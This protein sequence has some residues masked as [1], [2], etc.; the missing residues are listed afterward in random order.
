[1]VATEDFHFAQREERGITVEGFPQLDGFDPHLP[2]GHRLERDQHRVVAGIAHRALGD[3][4]PLARFGG[5]R[6]L[7]NRNPQ[8]AGKP[9]STRQVGGRPL[10]RQQAHRLHF[11]VL[12]EIDTQ[13]C[14]RIG[15]RAPFGNP[16][17]IAVFGGG[18]FWQT[19]RR[20]AIY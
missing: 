13:R 11:R 4:L 5:I 17:D 10:G 12:P 18:D 3:D 2:G 20:L 9:E 15:G 1:M 16:A 19:Q 6:G 8:L 14:A 7:G